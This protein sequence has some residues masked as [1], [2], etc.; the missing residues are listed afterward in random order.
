MSWSMLVFSVRTKS[1]S[2]LWPGEMS[3]PQAADLTNHHSNVSLNFYFS[4][5]RLIFLMRWILFTRCLYLRWEIMC[6]LMYSN[7]TFQCIYSNR[8]VVPVVHDWVAQNPHIQKG[9]SQDKVAQPHSE[10][11]E[12][13]LLSQF[14][15]PDCFSVSLFLGFCLQCHLK[16][17]TA[18]RW[19]SPNFDLAFKS[20][21]PLGN[22]QLAVFRIGTGPF[23]FIVG[24]MEST[25][26]IKL[27]SESCSHEC[28]IRGCSLVRGEWK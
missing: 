15:E 2:L 25:G 20:P 12:S 14:S 28:S 8:Q 19:H 23:L 26:W 18:S 7:E 21:V 27:P 11:V 6:Y 9:T 22:H 1:S 3:L 5:E 24:S 13:S 17:F 16:S 10:R 4:W